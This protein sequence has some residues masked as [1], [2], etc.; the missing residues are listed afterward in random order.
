MS[1]KVDINIA[2]L[3]I[4]RAY[5]KLSMSTS[6]P[7]GY[8][9]CQFTLLS[10]VALDELNAFLYWGAPINV[11]G[12]D[13]VTLWAGGI[14]KSEP[15][16]GTTNVNVTAVGKW[17]VA[18]DALFQRAYVDYGYAG[19][20]EGFPTAFSPY[21]TDGNS[22]NWYKWQTQSDRFTRDN[23]SRMFI[24]PTSDTVYN[25]LEGFFW[26]WPIAEY[27]R[28]SVQRFQG[29]RKYNLV[30]ASDHIRIGYFDEQYK[31]TDLFSA[32]GVSDGR[33]PVAFDY[34]IPPG[35]RWVWM[36]YY[37]NA[38]TQPAG[39]VNG[40]FE[41]TQP[42]LIYRTFTM[43]VTNV[44]KDI[45]D[46][47]GRNFGWKVDAP[48]VATNSTVI[49][50]LMFDQPVSVPEMLE[51]VNTLVDYEYGIDSNGSFYF[52]PRSSLIAARLTT[53]EILEDQLVW[54]FTDLYNQVYVRYTDDRQR[55]T[56]LFA[57]DTNPENYLNRHT[58]ESP[59]QTYLTIGDT[60]DITEQIGTTLSPHWHGQ[61]FILP[62][63]ARVTSL[64]VYHIC[65]AF[66]SAGYLDVRIWECT[67]PAGVLTLA[68]EISKTN[69]TY[70]IT[71]TSSSAPILISVNAAYLQ[72][73]INY[74]VLING[75]NN[76]TNSL[77]EDGNWTTFVNGDSYEISG[78]LAVGGT[79]SIVNTSYKLR[80]RLF[81]TMLTP[82]TRTGSIW[83]SDTQSDTEAE[84][85]A[86]VF[87][88]LHTYAK[89]SGDL[90]L[91]A[92]RY[93]YLKAGDLIQYQGGPY[94][95]QVLRITETNLD[96]EEGTIVVTLS[97]LPAGIRTVF[98]R[99]RI[100]R[101]RKVGISD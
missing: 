93:Y 50:Q 66:T 27:D 61:S 53:D 32:N 15:I 44:M 47:P 76:S 3:D 77:R 29:T 51:T 17:A 85:A 14:V 74:I 55:E 59:S 56:Y 48:Q 6:S 86:N 81:G 38:Y 41:I 52:Q 89:P 43:T 64:E 99:R 75:P 30:A 4:G 92:A 60:S 71:G 33:T 18:K 12:P 78:S 23:Y 39:N 97:D 22:N 25:E 24:Q 94:Y 62:Y 37:K 95:E 84:N 28:W 45:I 54:D 88:D 96:P 42:K 46:G 65:S 19:W 31:G 40:F 87:L 58:I 7:G 26:S 98:R 35:T 68:K 83:L 69:D 8:A 1:L 72:A 34:A 9:S 101:W 16:G 13:G 49:D 90:I 5:E 100:A 79:P 36:R 70:Q 57:E 2:G 20:I 67:K 63:D 11:T 10:S 21:W 73:G 82:T 91:D 80:L